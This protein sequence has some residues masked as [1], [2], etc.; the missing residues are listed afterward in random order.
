[1]LCLQDGLASPI[2]HQV[3][4]NPHASS[5]HLL[6]RFC[7]AVCLKQCC[8][9]WVGCYCQ[10]F[11]DSGGLLALWVRN[12]SGDLCRKANKR[13]LLFEC[14]TKAPRSAHTSCQG[15]FAEPLPVWGLNEA[16]GKQ[17]SRLLNLFRK[18]QKQSGRRKR[19]TKQQLWVQWEKNAFANQESLSLNKLV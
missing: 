13:S 5:K 14:C 3:L 6:A 16:L 17:G 2:M 7:L 8:N 12:R 18:V 4:L 11:K 1:M 15:H 10:G 9:T 19:I